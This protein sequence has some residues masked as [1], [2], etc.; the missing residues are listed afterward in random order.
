[1]ASVWAAFG[2]NGA[3]AKSGAHIDGAA[4]LSKWKSSHAEGGVRVVTWQ[5]ELMYRRFQA[6][7][8]ADDSFPVAD[9]FHDWGLYSQVLWGFR[10]GWVAGV[11]GDYLHMQDS[12]FT[13]DPD[14]QSRWRISA[15]L[16][17]YPTEF[18][19]LRLQ[20][21]HD[22]LESNFFLADRQVDSVFL[23]FEFIL[24]AHGA[25]KF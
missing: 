22:F 8:G 17:W 21:N 3:G 14:R 25:H 7:H 18:S 10:K 2:S 5:P 4:L 11:R 6:G 20:Y 12:R 15:N 9:T 23:Q 24:G 13:D 16:S 1:A 19:K